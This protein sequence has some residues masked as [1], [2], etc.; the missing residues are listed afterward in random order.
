MPKFPKGSQEAKDYM[1]S[2]RD[3]RGTKPKDPTAPKKLTKRQK[4]LAETVDIPL[5]G[6]S[7]LI[8]PEY[9]ATPIKNG[10]YKLVNPMSQERN[11]SQRNG[12]LSLKL[13]RK[14]V[15]NMILL[16]GNDEPIP[17]G[18]F[19]KKDRTIIDNHFQLVNKYSD[20][21]PQD[22]PTIYHK[23]PLE[24]G[25]PEILKKNVEINKQRGKKA[26]TPK[27]PKVKP[28]Q[29][30]TQPVAEEQPNIQMNIQEVS[31]KL[32]RP[33]KYESAEEKAKKKR[34]QTLESNRKKR[35][36]KKALKQQQQQAQIGTGILDQVKHFVFGNEGLPTKTK[37]MLKKYGDEKIQS[38]YL[39]RTPV[40][41]YITE[42]LNVA[43]LGDFNKKIK[44]ANYDKLFHLA[45]VFKTSKG[46]ILLEKN[47]NINMTESIPKVEGTET[48][49]LNLSQDITI[50]EVLERT[51]KYMGNDKFLKYDASTNNCQDFILS[52]LKGN[53][54]GNKT[55]EAFVK[56]DIES[57]FKS[58]PYLKPLTKNVLDIA[59]RFTG[60][61]MENYK[62]QSV[63]FDKKKYSIDDAKK[64]LKSNGYLSPKV[65]ETE[66]QLRFRQKDPDVLESLGFTSYRTKPLGKS[67]IQLI[68]AYYSDMEGRG[69]TGYRVA[70]APVEN[71]DAI[72][73]TEIEQDSQR[74]R[75]RDRDR[76]VEDE[77]IAE[78]LAKIEAE[79][80]AEMIAKIVQKSL[81]SEQRR[82]MDIEELNEKA[83]RKE[84]DASRFMERFRQNKLRQKFKEVKPN[85]RFDG[86]GNTASIYIPDYTLNPVYAKA[87]QKKE[88]LED[89]YGKLYNK[90]LDLNES[91]Q[92]EYNMH[93][94]SVLET[95]SPNPKM[96]ELWDKI[97]KI[98]VEKADKLRDKIDEVGK[99]LDEVNKFI[100]DF[101]VDRR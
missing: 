40:P 68:I 48:Q 92:K 25:R 55:D 83:R 56:Q 62:I 77:V 37:N 45:I 98:Y 27:Q 35:A 6:S 18:K 86:R 26:K 7:T 19:S 94:K 29:Q 76:E 50:N 3:K 57:L 64:W 30:I 53:G 85:R 72:M 101:E 96:F 60:T 21:P 82:Q 67:G 1:K 43:S 93:F 16:E 66:T 36:E 33:T 2:L 42:L 15:E 24:R 84:E 4:E 95:P 49:N 22:V 63:I 71:Y 34:E 90:L 79:E 65:D 100:N 31:K 70:P 44:E 69:N 54:F 74:V 39:I 52:I 91:N 89:E 99:K 8:L 97:S 87:V 47:E 14:P 13:I 81:A 61:G 59:N 38:I 58:S 28:I 20:K 78:E 9:F 88:E 41:K 17:L 73:P 46:E 32:G 80:L 23:K 51:K 11:L 10:K 5:M 12:K 75:D